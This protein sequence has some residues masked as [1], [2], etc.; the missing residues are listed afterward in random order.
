MITVIGPRDNFG[1]DYISTVSRSN[2]WSRGLSPFFLGPV[3]G[4][5]GKTAKNVE[6]LWQ[7][8]KVYPLHLIDGEPNEAYFAW[9]DWGWDLDRAER[10]PAGKGAI[11]AYSYWETL[12][13]KG[14]WIPQKLSYVEARK[15]IYIPTYAKA[16][17]KAKAYDTLKSIYAEKDNIVLWDFDGYDHR[18]LGKSYDEVVNDPN[19]KCGHAFVLAMLLEGYLK[20]KDNIIIWT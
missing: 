10:Y 16:V 4:Y 14:Q 7:F 5:G 15:A 19:K 1:G 8:S 3:D 11:P 2:N 12:D 20:V 13:S 17:V 6:N 18:A 9:R